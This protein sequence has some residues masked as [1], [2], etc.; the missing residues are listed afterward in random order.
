MFQERKLVRSLVSPHFAESFKRSA[1]SIGAQGI[2]GGVSG[3]AK[4]WFI[5]LIHL[6]RRRSDDGPHGVFDDLVVGM[7]RPPGEVS[8]RLF[9]RKDKLAARDPILFRV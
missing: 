6:N 3:A 7:A 9:E 8:E 1:G 2:V 4:L 5:W